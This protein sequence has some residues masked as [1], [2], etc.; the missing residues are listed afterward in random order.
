[1]YESKS[2]SLDSQQNVEPFM[3]KENFIDISDSEEAEDRNSSKVLFSTKSFDKNMN[4]FSNN[5]MDENKE[6]K[7]NKNGKA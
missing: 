7:E 3:T 5:Q 1:M 2:P 6:R 4:D